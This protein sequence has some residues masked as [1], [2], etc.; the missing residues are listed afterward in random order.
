MEKKLK[1]GEQ[2]ISIIF[3]FFITFIAFILNNV[4]KLD[5]LVNMIILFSFLL[6]FLI[7]EKKFNFK[8]YKLINE[9]FIARYYSGHRICANFLNMSIVFFFF[10]FIFN[11]KFF[12]EKSIAYL[13]FLFIGLLG[14]L[15]VDKLMD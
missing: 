14:P 6:I 11:D 7:L 9:N 3:T 13:P 12:T 15:F 4:V 10:S 1:D 5:Y 2:F 8:S